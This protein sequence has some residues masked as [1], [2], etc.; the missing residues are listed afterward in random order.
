[1]A[2][3]SIALAREAEREAHEAFLWYYE[4]SQPSGDRFEAELIEALPVPVSDSP[5]RSPGQLRPTS[6]SPLCHKG[7]L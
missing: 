3:R 4:R 6:S 5:G 2:R 7:A 1:M